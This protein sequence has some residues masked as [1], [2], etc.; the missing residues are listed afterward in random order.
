[1]RVTRMRTAYLW[2]SLQKLDK[3]EIGGHDDYLSH[4]LANVS[5]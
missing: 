1:M 3:P 4:E 5:P 2:T